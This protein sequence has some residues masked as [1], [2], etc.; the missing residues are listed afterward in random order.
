ML[1]LLGKQDPSQDQ[2]PVTGSLSC[3][4]QESFPVKWKSDERLSLVLVSRQLLR[5]A[6]CLGLASL[7]NL[8]EA[9]NIPVKPAKGE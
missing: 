6:I 3:S 5:A 9:G 2:K 4:M 8:Q 7:T 1:F